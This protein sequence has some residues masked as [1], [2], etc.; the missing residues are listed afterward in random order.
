V[1]T[2]RQ[3]STIPD[4]SGF[5]SAQRRGPNRLLI[6]LTL[7]AVLGAVAAAVWYQTRLVLPAGISQ[8]DYE[9]ARQLFRQR[10]GR[11]GGRVDVLSL[12]GEQS[13]AAG[14]LEQAAVCFGEIPAGHPQYGT[15]SRLQ[16]GQVLMRLNRAAE[17][18]QAFRQFLE[19]VERDADADPEHLRTA[20]QWLV[21]LL[22]VQQRL[23]DRRQVLAC[24]HERQLAGVWESK[25]YYF[26]YQLLWN[27]MDG[28]ERLLKFL[29]HDPDN[30]LLR[31]AH[32]RY[33]IAAGELD[34]AWPVLAELQA[35]EPDDPGIA[36]AVLEY[37][38]ERADWD[39]FARAA[40]TI[41]PFA[42]GEPWQLTRMRGELALHEQRWEDALVEFARVLADE[43]ANPWSH[44]GLARASG[45]LGRSQQ[46]EQMLHRSKIL[47]DIRVN[48]YNVSES[49]PDGC[50]DLAD[51]CEQLQMPQAARCFRQHARR[52]EQQAARLS[53]AGRRPGGTTQQR[54]GE[55]R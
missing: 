38:F 43:P 33:L 44:M 12:L 46:R 30:P 27:S 50:R 2:S 32:G 22:S 7:L 52:I 21:Y 48:M 45:R 10:Y 3:P 41:P 51:K 42:P 20:C 11:S 54:P 53:T 55:N 35:A 6:A 14:R 49:D 26:P 36:A 29:E 34:A 18:E 23:E 37:H 31:L 25:L 15:S 47:A 5:P 24:M 8:H 28:H 16:A 40:A 19:L 4:A 9:L 17:A 1:Q 13:V 39:A